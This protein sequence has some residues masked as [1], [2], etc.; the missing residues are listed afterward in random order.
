[1]WRDDHDFPKN[2]SK[3]FLR[4]MLDISLTGFR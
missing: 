2:G 4:E 3:I 1:M